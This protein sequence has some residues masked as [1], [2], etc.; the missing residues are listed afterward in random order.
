MGYEW[1]R[2]KM[3]YSF[4]K[5][6][7]IE[8]TPAYFVEE[9][10]PERVYKMNNSIKLILIVR[11]P[12]ER[13]ISDYT[14][15]HMTKLSKGKEHESFEE[16]AIDQETGEV[17][18]PYRAIRRSIYHRHLERWLRYFPINQ[19][20]ILSAEALVRDPVSQLKIVESFLGIEHKISA[21]NFYYNRTKGYFC[22]R[23]E[24]HEKCL[25]ESKGR[26]HPSVSPEVVK[27]LQDFFRPHNYK[28]YRM[29]DK[30][31]GWP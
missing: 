21:A 7:T 26:P 5:Q 28:F 13:A 8:K 18:T 3:P 24:T 30:D 6:I 23:N 15:I 2:R 29:V 25:A 16:L 19:L 1:Y 10:V 27:K 4:P 20:L 31:F 9:N 12:T 17:R 22:M 11:D 14:Q